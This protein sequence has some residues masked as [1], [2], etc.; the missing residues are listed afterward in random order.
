MEEV[1]LLSRASAKKKMVF[2]KPLGGVF[3]LFGG[4]FVLLGGGFVLFGSVK[5]AKVLEVNYLRRFWRFFQKKK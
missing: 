3:V 2:L 1:S 5:D 4:V